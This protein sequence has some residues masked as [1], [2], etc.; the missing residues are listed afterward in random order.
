MRPRRLALSC[1]LL[2]CLACHG[3][4]HGLARRVVEM[5]GQT[6]ATATRLHASAAYPVCRRP[7]VDPAAGC[8]TDP[9]LIGTAH[10]DLLEDV[11][12]SAAAGDSVD[13]AHALA[14][15]DLIWANDE[16]TVD[17]AI[18]RLAPLASTRDS[19]IFLNDL[20]VAWE[21]KA[22][23]SGRTADWTRALDY[24]ERATVAAATPITLLNR[25]VLLE[26]FRMNT[27]ARAAWEVL[28]GQPDAGVWKA[29]A[30]SRAGALRDA[31][32]ADA[33]TA[34]FVAVLAAADSASLARARE[35][36]ATFPQ[37]ARRFAT[38]RALPAWSNA[39]R[40]GDTIAAARAIAVVEAIGR[41]I[42]QRS[43]DAGIADEA[44]GLRAGRITDRI[45]EAYIAYAAAEEAFES[46]RFAE[47]AKHAGRAATLAGFRET[48]IAPWAVYALGIDRVMDD[49]FRAG[50]SIFVAILA[51]PVSADRHSLRGRALW[52]RGLIAARQ[53]RGGTA[54]G[55]Y[56]QSIEALRRSAEAEYTAGISALMVEQYARSG[57][58]LEA[59]DR[60]ADAME[61]MSTHRSSMYLAD[62]Y[63]RASDMASRGGSAHAALAFQREGLA[64]AQATRRIQQPVEA[65]IN[66]GLRLAALGHG[67]EADSIWNDAATRLPTV[68]DEDMRLRIATDLRNARIGAALLP[69]L[70][71]GENASIDSIT[72]TLDYF[73]GHGLGWL[74]ATTLHQR[75][76]AYLLEGDTAAARSDLEEA[77]SLIVDALRDLAAPQRLPLESAGRAI[78][79][80]TQLL[81]ADGEVERALAISDITR[82]VQLGA[83]DLASVDDVTL[84]AG[85][86]VITMMA[87]PDE[88]LVW[89]GDDR[90]ITIERR[91][92]TR[93]ALADSIDAFTTHLRAGRP[94][95]SSPAGSWL[96]RTL[97]P[98][99]DALPAEL[100]VIADA[101]I[102]RLPI[103]AL[104]IGDGDALLLDRTVLRTVPAIRQLAS[105]TG[106]PRRRAGEALLVAG[107]GDPEASLP[108]LPQVR[109]EVG[110]IAA[111][112]PDARV[113][114]PSARGS[115]ADELERATLFH[116]AGHTVLGASP[117]DS[118]LVL[119]A[120]GAPRVRYL[121]PADLGSGSYPL[122]DTVVLSS[123]RTLDP[124]EATGS[125]LP[126]F[127]A[128]FMRAGATTVVGTLWPIDDAAA[129]DL[130]VSFHR[131]LRDGM[132][133]AEALALSQ[134][135]ARD[136]QTGAHANVW[137]SFLVLTR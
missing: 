127:A 14:L 82:A 8:D 77:V 137:A 75:A 44:A 116:F 81:V 5:G 124:G 90:D 11:H 121:R 71:A 125:G 95:R 89:H 26:R 103:A 92:V 57:D 120:E 38:L 43:G 15:L 55:F 126:A 30:D 36:A 60:L 49:D 20:T 22:R 109:A 48:V 33:V 106:E 135:E 107:S 27:L 10:R 119:R 102:A 69:G 78:E 21:R 2:I 51:H 97:F 131:R 110:A 52:G 96:A 73:R 53:F 87:L 128:A 64:V 134:R 47:M 59:W 67:L 41:G 17:R 4:D 122:L 54:L 34:D 93:D 132:P 112:R 3:E 80:L 83:W 65:S 23:F 42:E 37:I 19:A 68:P 1:A 123:C 13:A 86:T 113:L 70:R 40:S 98:E 16:R 104:P 108:E 12:R 61:A 29:E 91:A 35:T 56:Q 25:A 101:L 32:E 9:P 99:P 72:R 105:P 130:M 84:P 28:A 46:G 136:R 118:R 88:L 117:L 133:P 74:T 18:D 129:V 39:Y 115:V 76:E 111:F 6:L 50:D 31:P 100:S 79:R 24:A 94:P 58:R 114:D 66:L 45:A 62:A 7:A 63:R 85:R